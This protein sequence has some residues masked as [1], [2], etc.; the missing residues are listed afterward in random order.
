MCPTSRLLLCLV[1]QLLPL[2]VGVVPMQPAPT[3]HVTLAWDDT[4]NITQDGYLVRRRADT[5]GSAYFALAS[6]DATTRTYTDTAVVVNQRV[7][8]V[9]EAFQNPQVE[10]APSNEVCTRARAK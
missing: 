2:I 4:K 7:C 5:P 10:S 9:V 3:P 1:M 8:Y 6:V